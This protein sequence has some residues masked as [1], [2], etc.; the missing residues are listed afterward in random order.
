L[1]KELLIKEKVKPFAFKSDPELTFC[2]IPFDPIPEAGMPERWA[3]FL[4]NFTNVN[5]ICMWV[6][7]LFFE[8]SDRSQYLWLYG[9]GGNGKSTMARVISKLLG[10]FVRFEQAPAKD[11]KYW[12]A[13]LQN[14][15][16][17]VIDD[18]NNYGFVK[19]GLFKSLT[20]S[21]KVRVEDKF[22]KAFDTDLDCK[23]LFTSNELPMVSDDVADQRRIIFASALNNQVF[24]YDPS[25][26]SGL[27]ES[28]PGFVSYCMDLY[29]LNCHDG[30]P[31]PTDNKEALQLAEIFDEEVSAWLENVGEFK[32]ECF[33][34][35]A[36]F[37][38]VL[39]Q[40]RLNP[41]HVYKYL[42]NQGVVR[43]VHKFGEK[44]AKALKG[45][46]LKIVA[47]RF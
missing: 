46:N 37:R 22:C 2:R 15:R 13:G 28:L 40:T 26:E 3:N 12:S 41:R 23:F 43:V 18:C 33:T 14:K 1:K 38:S 8:H 10:D 6:G 32:T 35:V 20:G 45:F 5:A 30:R 44:P 31:V 25:F 4:K 29:S 19:T 27:A 9:K 39:S 47:S 34:P 16:L 7:S 36:E 42:E 21:S 11:D 17:I 24:D